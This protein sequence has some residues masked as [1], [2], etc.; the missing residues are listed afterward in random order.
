MEL[1]YNKNTIEVLKLTTCDGDTFM[2][3]R[4]GYN[5]KRTSEAQFMRA[6]LAPH[7]KQ[8][9]FYTVT[10]DEVENHALSELEA[11]TLG[12]AILQ[13]NRLTFAGA[14]NAPG[15]GPFDKAF[16]NIIRYCTGKEL[17]YD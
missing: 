11:I 7:T 6:I 9:E 3:Q 10:W 15:N 8:Y 12:N 5:F 13:L 16:Q 2:V 14:F 1:V 17:I 4:A